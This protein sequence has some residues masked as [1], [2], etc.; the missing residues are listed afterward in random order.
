MLLASSYPDT[1]VKLFCGFPHRY[2]NGKYLT[3]SY[4]E[5]IG[6]EVHCIDEEI[7]F[8]IPQNWCWVRH[9]ELFELSGGSQPPKDLFKYEA[10]KGYIRLYQIRDYGE[11]PLPVYI[12][13]ISA[14]KM[15]CK[16][17]ILLARYGASLG[18]V[19][20]AESGAYNVAMAKIIPLFDSVKNSINNDYLFLYYHTSLYQS[21]I[22]SISRSAQAGFNKG[23]LQQMLFLLPPLSEQERIVKA[24]YNVENIFTKAEASLK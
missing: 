17:D 19:F 13:V 1:S 4:Y 18:K 21:V 16:G 20:R 2:Y 14:N 23:D 12:P 5:K 11:H 10:E 6:E 8:E 15:T 24:F 9:N 7:P 22:F 3:I